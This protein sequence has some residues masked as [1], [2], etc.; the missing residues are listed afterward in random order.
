MSGLQGCF[1]VIRALGVVA[2][3]YLKTEF[4][5]TGCKGFRVQGLRFLAHGLFGFQKCVGNR[6]RHDLQPPKFRKPSCFRHGMLG[7]GGGG[8]GGACRPAYVEEEVAPLL[9]GGGRPPH[10]DTKP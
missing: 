8:G 2:G 7:A 3:R 5:N 4:G 10:E 1:C 9:F 6:R